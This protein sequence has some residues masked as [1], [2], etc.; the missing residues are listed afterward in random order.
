VSGDE[1]FVSASVAEDSFES[2]IRGGKIRVIV[3]GEEPLFEMPVRPEHLLEIRRPCGLRI[4]LDGLSDFR[5]KTV[6]GTSDSLGRSFPPEQLRGFPD[7]AV[8]IVDVPGRGLR[9][10]ESDIDVLSELAQQKR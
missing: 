9:H 1:A 8:K 7:E 5:Q 6:E 4:P 3:A 2:I 10:A